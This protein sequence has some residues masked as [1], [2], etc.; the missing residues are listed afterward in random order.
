MKSEFFH[1]CLDV[2]LSMGLAECSGRIG[3]TH[4]ELD[5][6][7]RCLD[8]TKTIT[9]SLFKSIDFAEST[10]FCKK[11]L[12]WHLSYRC[13]ERKIDCLRRISDVYLRL[14]DYTNCLLFTYRYGNAII[15]SPFSSSLRKY[16][17][18]NRFENIVGMLS[19][20]PRQSL[21]DHRWR[22]ELLRLASHCFAPNKVRDTISEYCDQLLDFGRNL[23]AGCCYREIEVFKD[24][25]E[26]KDSHRFAT[27]NLQRTPSKVQRIIRG[28]DLSK[29]CS[30]EL[31]T[32]QPTF[33]VDE[34][35][36]SAIGDATLS[37]YN[38]VLPQ[39]A[40][41]QRL[42]AMTKPQTQRISD[43]DQLRLGKNAT[44]LGC[45]NVTRCWSRYL[46]GLSALNEAKT[47]GELSDLWSGTDGRQLKHIP[48]ARHI[49]ERVLIDLGSSNS[50][51]KRKVQRSLALVLGPD[52]SS[53]ILRINSSELIH[54]SINES[55][56]SRFRKQSYSS[57]KADN[58]TASSI[59]RLKEVRSNIPEG[60]QFLAMAS[61]PTGE[62]LLDII[63]SSGDEQTCCVFPPSSESI[64]DFLMC[65][66]SD[67]LASNNSQLENSG[68][69]NREDTTARRCWRRERRDMDEAFAQLMQRA[70]DLFVSA[71]LP[72]KSQQFLFGR[73]TGNL[74]SRFEEVADEDRDDTKQTSKTCLVLILDEMLQKFPF[75]SLEFFEERAIC[76]LPSL[77]FVSGSSRPSTEIKHERVSYILNPESDLDDTEERLSPLLVGLGC[78]QWESYVK[79][80]PPSSDFCHALRQESGLIM[81]FGHGGGERVISK[82]QLKAVGDGDEGVCASVILMGCSSG[83]LHSPNQDKGSCVPCT[84]H[85]EP[86]GLILQ[87]LLLG[88]PC[89]IGNLWDVTDRDI[90]LFTERM[91]RSLFEGGLSTAQSVASARSACKY[92]FLTGG[93]PVCYGLPA[94]IYK[95][96]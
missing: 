78:N 5:Y 33:A 54:L 28:H 65:P 46:L 10:S 27:W 93:A 9:S 84:M 44:T 69:L 30:K 16:S 58:W 87:Y 59:Q 25:S 56:S 49:L 19:A 70:K 52:Q 13:H 67:I 77:F 29:E 51:L 41:D 15:G 7:L 89:A 64:S 86:D 74:S 1:G 14:G 8:R 60:L 85:F 63:A 76:R 17:H 31:I 39:L 83:L 23:A 68:N 48:N 92:R 88:S 26:G 53:D 22:R 75:E 34:C 4:G 91:L 43:K 66:L 3:D 61:C 45:T 12:H 94:Y 82:D 95:K 62:L 96:T 81:Y 32:N 11:A 90:D 50:D 72:L 35:L 55:I 37:A 79:K 42:D 71:N 57:V 36:S 80:K 73:I 6:L 24:A 20:A 2:T 18:K 21:Q 40:C 47:N 38:E